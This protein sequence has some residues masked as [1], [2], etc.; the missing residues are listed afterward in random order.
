MRPWKFR[1][2]LGLRWALLLFLIGGAGL[3]WISRHVV[4]HAEEQKL[5][6]A[7]HASK[8]YTPPATSS[9]SIFL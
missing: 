6:A 1:L 3:G 9:I 8:A 4:Q 7:I 2:Q 5:V